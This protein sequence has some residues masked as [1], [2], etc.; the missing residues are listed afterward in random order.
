MP[1]RCIDTATAWDRRRPFRCILGQ[2][3]PATTHR[4]RSFAALT[5]VKQLRWPSMCW[6]ARAPRCDSTFLHT[7]SARS[8]CAQRSSGMPEWVGRLQLRGPGEGCRDAAG[9][10]R[11]PN[12]NAALIEQLPRWA[13][14]KTEC[15]H[16]GLAGTAQDDRMVAPLLYAAEIENVLGL[17][18]DQKP[19][20]IDIESAERPRSLRP[21]STWFARTTLKGGSKI[22]V[23]RGIP[24]RCLRRLRRL[25]THRPEGK[26]YAACKDVAKFAAGRALA[27]S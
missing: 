4:S 6:A 5:G 8:I 18:A 15:A 10:L 24:Y 27:R 9:R 12:Q 23:R 25:L 17:V 13:I 3:K 19:K 26:R 2:R 1:L 22:G 21:S 11:R 20:A 16:L 7:P 14:L